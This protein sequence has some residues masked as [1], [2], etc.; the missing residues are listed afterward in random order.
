MKSGYFNSWAFITRLRW[1][2]LAGNVRRGQLLDVSLSVSHSDEWSGNAFPHAPSAK[3]LALHTVENGTDIEP[4]PFLSPA[5]KVNVTVLCRRIIFIEHN[6]DESLIRHFGVERHFV[7]VQSTG[8]ICYWLR[9]VDDEALFIW[10]RASPRT[11]RPSTGPDKEVGQ[12]LRVRDFD[13]SAEVS[14]FDYDL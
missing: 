6:I 9:P 10:R 8:L 7:A 13:W 14:A 1:E 12:R 4:I 3:P 2:K 11:T 5:G